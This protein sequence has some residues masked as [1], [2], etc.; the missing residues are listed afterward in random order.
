MNII[1]VVKPIWDKWAKEDNTIQTYCNLFINDVML[2]QDYH[3]FEGRVANTMIDIMEFEKWKKIESGDWKQDSIVLAA[4]KDDPHG[5]INILLPGD[6]IQSGKWNKLVPLCANIG[7][8]NFFGK[9]INFAFRIEPT[10]YQFSL[11]T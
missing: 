11:L 9:G 3:G 6:L 10:Y 1:E 8:D 7:K 5:H 2:T 4:R